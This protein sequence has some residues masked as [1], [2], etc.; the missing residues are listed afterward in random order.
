M[1]ASV[2]VELLDWH[3][4][5]NAVKGHAADPKKDVPMLARVHVRIEPDGNAY[6]M[7]TDRTT[8]GLAIVTVWEDHVATGELVSFDLT[9][10]DVGKL[11]AVFK[12]RKGG[13]EDRLRLD[14]A[15]HT[16][17][18]TE[19]RGMIEVKGDSHHQLLRQPLAE[20]YPDLG[21]V[22]AR[23][24]REATALRER[25]HLDGALGEA[26]AE[27]VFARADLMSRFTAAA[28]AYSGST[29]AIE[30]TREA[31]SAL[32]ISVG[33]SFRGVL[34]PVRPE[35]DEVA[36]HRQWHQDWLRRLPDPD[37]VP[38]SMPDR[39]AAPQPAPSDDEDRRPGPDDV[40]LPDPDDAVGA[41]R[42]LLAQAAE[43]VIST[44]FG[45]TSMI[46]RKLRV[47]FAKAGRLMDL[48]EA[49][50]VVGA[51]DG[52]RARQV[53]V[54]S[55]DQA[56]AV[57][58]RIRD[59]EVPRLQVA[60][61]QGVSAELVDAVADM[62]QGGDVTITTSL[63]PREG[64]VGPS[65]TTVAFKEADVPALRELAGALRGSEQ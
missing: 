7:A 47:G 42:E 33:E 1:E 45:S 46:Q 6:L 29:L 38:V 31:R 23:C 30:R 2:E 50:G 25:A 16:I 3:R 55:A 10:E 48:L 20:E 39:A 40:P 54:A 53:L 52:S 12:P 56:Q 21:K 35:D 19:L 44:Q 27:E 13:E 18:V 17:R 60:V 15:A 8:V 26:A 43:L 28:A 24:I 5:L 4:A 34:M 9:S 51:A 41:D 49:C 59:G 62:V 14:I 57:A 32:L 37:D 11:L 22:V 65:V 61:E 36:S 58:Q 63:A 64:Q